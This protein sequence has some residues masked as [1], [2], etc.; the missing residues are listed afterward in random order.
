MALHFRLIGTITWHLQGDAG[1]HLSSVC[2]SLV[3]LQQ[4]SIYMTFILKTR[5]Q[6]GTCI[7]TYCSC[8]HH[9]LGRKQW[10]LTMRE[11]TP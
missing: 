1:L 7:L 6:E 2:L 4:P 11:V 5:T 10:H 8:Q 3:F 9:P